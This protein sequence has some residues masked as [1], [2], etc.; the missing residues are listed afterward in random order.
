MRTGAA[1]SRAGPHR[2]HGQGAAG[3]RRPP[4]P[5]PPRRCRRPGEGGALRQDTVTVDW[6][7]SD[8][9]AEIL[10]R[11]AAALDDPDVVE[12]RVQA[13]LTTD[14]AARGVVSA[15]SYQNEVNLSLKMKTS[16]PALRSVELLRTTATGGVTTAL[17]LGI[18]ALLDVA[19]VTR[20][21]CNE[22]AASLWDDRVLGRFTSLRA[23]NLSHGNLTSLPGVVG[24]LAHLQELRL[25]GNKLKILPPELGRLSRLRV[26]AADRNELSILPGELRRCAEL[27]ELTLE[28]NRLTSVLLNFSAFPR[29]AV[30]HLFNNPLEFLPEIAPCGELRDLSVANLRVSADREFAAFRVELLAPAPAGAAINMSLFD[31]KNTDALRPIFSLMLRRSS[32]HHQLLAGALSASSQQRTA[33]PRC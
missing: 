14:A 4:L 2:V 19:A 21:R 3:S 30:L 17:G 25:V 15:S 29:L 24:A 16:K 5:P 8:S 22:G 26:L 20:L 11:I 6:L 13:R 7:S 33:A 28:D 32:G 31:S 23:L 27:E 1:A 10:R 18:W 9:E 12:E